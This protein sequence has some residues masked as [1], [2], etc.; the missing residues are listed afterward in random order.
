MPL[1][2]A[3]QGQH[4]WWT[5][6]IGGSRRTL[7]NWTEGWTTAKS[8]AH[9]GRKVK[10]IPTPT[11]S[12]FTDRKTSRTDL[13]CLKPAEDFFFYSFSPSVLLYFL[14][15]SSFLPLP[16]Y[17]F[18]LPSFIFSFNFCYNSFFSFL[19]SFFI[20]SSFLLSFPFLLL[21]PS[22]LF[23]LPPFPTGDTIIPGALKR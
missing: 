17:S 16:F 1:I 14:I 13:I 10:P 8:V 4:N 15:P 12:C 9:E 5:K 2:G 20:P 3:P 22:F 6:G 23:F 19:R 21:F 11:P 7:R 18:F